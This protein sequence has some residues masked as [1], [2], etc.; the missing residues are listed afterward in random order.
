LVVSIQEI[1]GA[2]THTLQIESNMSR[3]ELALQTK[4]RRMKRKR[5]TL[6]NQDEIEMDLQVHVLHFV[7]K[8]LPECSGSGQ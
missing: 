2:F 4:G 6:S 7:S 3:H 8:C 1:E 5:V